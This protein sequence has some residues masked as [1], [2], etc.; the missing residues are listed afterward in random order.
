MSRNRHRFGA[1]AFLAGLVSVSWCGGESAVPASPNGVPMLMNGSTNYAPASGEVYEEYFN[2][3]SYAKRSY[4]PGYTP[5]VSSLFENPRDYPWAMGALATPYYNYAG[6]PGWFFGSPKGYQTSVPPNSQAHAYFAGQL[7]ITSDMRYGYPNGLRVIEPIVV[8]VGASVKKGGFL[9][10]GGG[11]E[12]IQV[13]TET[14]MMAS[15]PAPT[16]APPAPPAPCPPPPAGP[17]PYR[18]LLEK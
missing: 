11:L 4:A 6:M 16:L 2:Y 9:I 10:T 5:H 13:T 1:T 14:A 8:P 12:Q 7:G 17:A 3:S 18:E 15:P